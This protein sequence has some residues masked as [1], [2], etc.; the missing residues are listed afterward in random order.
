V[1]S[2]KVQYRWI[3]KNQESAAS[4]H[5]QTV[6]DGLSSARTYYD[7]TQLRTGILNSRTTLHV[8]SLKFSVSMKMQ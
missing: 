6:T 7:V 2:F 8:D 1:T 4:S 3:D 5:W